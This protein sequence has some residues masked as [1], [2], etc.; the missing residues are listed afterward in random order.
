MS[1]WAHEQLE[2]HYLVSGQ[3]KKYVTSISSMPEPA[4]WSC[5]TGQRRPCIDSCQLTI[6]WKFN[7]KDLTLTKAVIV[8]WLPSP[9][10]RVCTDGRSDGRSY[11]HVTTKFFWLDGLP[12]FLTHAAPLARFARWSSAINFIKTKKG[13]RCKHLRRLA[14]VSSTF[15]LLN[16]DGSVLQIFIS[17]CYNK[18]IKQIPNHCWTSCGHFHDVT[19]YYSNSFT[20]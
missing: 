2:N 9:S 11:G 18:D 5:D 12:K 7:I 8:L 4:I 13:W 16:F 20:R 15:Q 3:L 19:G 17:C 1:T 10:P 6:T 14:M